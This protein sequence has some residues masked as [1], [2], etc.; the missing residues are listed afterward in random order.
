MRELQAEKYEAIL[1]AAFELFGTHGFYET[2]ISDIAEKAGIAKGTVYLYFN[3][4]EKLFT[5]VSKRDFDLFL[6]NLREGLR[7]CGSLEECLRFIAVHHLTYYY[8]RKNRTNL[9]FRVPNSDPELMR[10][11]EIF[12][13]EYNTMLTEVLE[14]AGIPEER[15]H[16]KAYIGILNELKMDILFNPDYSDQDLKMNIQFASRL[17]MRGCLK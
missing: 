3:S 6:D 4:K 12:L 17:F 8:E 7:K 5:A 11:M 9:F 14:K 2:K 13:K 10:S 16:A 15:L 1:D